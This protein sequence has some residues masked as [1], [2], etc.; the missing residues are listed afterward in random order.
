M[1]REIQNLIIATNIKITIQVTYRLQPSE[2][3][4]RRYQTIYTNGYNT[5]VRGKI[6]GLSLG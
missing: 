5:T 6:I 2:N 4:L 1:N 3:E